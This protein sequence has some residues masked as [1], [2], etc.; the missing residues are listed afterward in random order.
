MDPLWVAQPDEWYYVLRTEDGWALVV[1]EGDSLSSSE[2]IQIDP[3]VELVAS[4]RAIPQLQLWLVVRA[5]TPAYSVPMDPLWVALPG[6]WYSVALEEDG[7]ALVVWEGDPPDSQ[8]WIQI[9][10][11]VELMRI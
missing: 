8:E 6:E 7:W 3:R 11:R 1:W 2:W 5:P 9:D 10:D 4:D